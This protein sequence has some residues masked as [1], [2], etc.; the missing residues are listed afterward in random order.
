MKP[1]LVVLGVVV[2]ILACVLFS[3]V[4]RLNS[5]KSA[6]D[7][8][9]LKIGDLP[10]GWNRSLLLNTEKKLEECKRR[11]IFWGREGVHRA[12]SE[13]VN[14]RSSLE[15]SIE[16][17]KLLGSDDIGRKLSSEQRVGYAKGVPEFKARLIYIRNN[18]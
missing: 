10:D 4:M 5:A 11:T 9:Y 18:M 12:L 8:V 3:D 6:I 13:V 2:S 15:R 17:M 7:D 1:Y 16:N 14:Q